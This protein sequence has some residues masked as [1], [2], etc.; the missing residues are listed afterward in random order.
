MSSGRSAS[1]VNTTA[2]NG[3]RWSARACWRRRTTR[4]TLSISGGIPEPDFIANMMLNSAQDIPL[5][6]LNIASYNNPQMDELLA[7]GHAVPGCAAADRAPIYQQVQAIAL[8]DM[9]TITRH[10]D[11]R[12]LCV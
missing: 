11:G 8:E 2:Q 6:G 5:A 9:H 1:R 12:A 3:S 7:S 10:L 4:S